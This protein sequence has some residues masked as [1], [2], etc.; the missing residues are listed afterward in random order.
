MPG[1][2]ST[3]S[4]RSCT[5]SPA[6]SPTMTRA[7][8]WPRSV[9]FT[10]LPMRLMKTPRSLGFVAVHKARHIAHALDG[11]R[12]LALF[13]AQPEHPLEILEGAVEIECLLAQFHVARFDL[14]HLQDIVDQCQQ[15]LSAPMD[16]LEILPLLAGDAALPQ[17][18]ALEKPRTGRTSSA[19][20]FR[21]TY[22]RGMRLRAGCR[23]WPPLWPARARC[24]TRFCSSILRRGAK[25]ISGSALR[26]P[27]ASGGRGKY[28][29]DTRHRAGACGTRDRA[30]RRS[31]SRLR[32][33]AHGLGQ[34]V[35]MITS[36]QPWPMKL[37]IE[38]SKYSTARVL[39]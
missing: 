39:T 31:R 6:T 24:S 19:Y 2:V 17:H 3:I 27:A 16:R 18:E 14:R 7:C 11:K 29:S 13:R 32:P 4:A 25:L 15:V 21:G 35:G 36:C 28:A 37:S 9:N 12:E 5:L 23:S 22:W 30:S 34:I 38:R 8:T 26:C 20:G 1:P 33:E 10:A